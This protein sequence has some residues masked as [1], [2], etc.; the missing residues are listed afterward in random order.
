MSVFVEAKISSSDFC[1]IHFMDSLFV[2]DDEN[3]INKNIL[4]LFIES[5]P[6]RRNINLCNRISDQSHAFIRM[7]VDR[8]IWKLFWRI[9]TIN[10][11]I[12]F[13]IFNSLDDL[14]PSWMIVSQLR[15]IIY[16]VTENKIGFGLVKFFE[17]FYRFR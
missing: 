15:S 14:I 5:S 3:F 6:N 17:G 10:K 2:V 12:N 8:C 1:E 11:S 13:S 9:H 16:V 4:F 7:R